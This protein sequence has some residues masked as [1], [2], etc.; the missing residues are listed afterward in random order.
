MITK[1]ESVFL[2]LC[3]ISIVT[4]IIIDLLYFSGNINMNVPFLTSINLV[5][6][7]MAYLSFRLKKRIEKRI[8]RRFKSSSNPL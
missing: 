2:F 7:F 4:I 8:K 3:N 6:T 5:I 1:R